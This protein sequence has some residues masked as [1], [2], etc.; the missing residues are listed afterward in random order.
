M[1]PIP[2]Q[3]RDR[4]GVWDDR[5]ERGEDYLSAPSSALALEF[6]FVRKRA[7]STWRKRRAPRTFIWYDFKTPRLLQRRTVLTWTWRRFATSRTVSIGSVPRLINI[8]HAS[9][10]QLILM[11]FNL[12]KLCNSITRRY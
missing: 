8:I 12:P 4:V 3:V 7:T 2:Y 11:Y 10:Q 5:E 1:D 9:I 6:I